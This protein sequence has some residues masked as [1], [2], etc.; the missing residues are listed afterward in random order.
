MEL[1]TLTRAEYESTVQI[2]NQRDSGDKEEQLKVSR[3]LEGFND[4]G[5][6]LKRL[7]L[8]A[9]RRH[10]PNGAVI[11]S[12]GSSAAE[13]LLVVQGLVHAVRPVHYASTSKD[14]KN[15]KTGDEYDVI[16][17]TLIQGKVMGASV[18]LDPFNPR[19]KLTYKC[20]TAVEVIVL[21]KEAFE[22][23]KVTSGVMMSLERASIRSLSIEACTRVIDDKRKDAFNRTMVLRKLKFIPPRRHPDLVEKEWLRKKEAMA[24]EILSG[25]TG[26]TDSLVGRYR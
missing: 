2:V 21:G 10:Y 6:E 17:A 24:D 5:Q 3:A 18:V 26:S 13:L 22:L 11:A 20:A 9:Q 4:Q 25:R 19:Y 12:I 1:L 7:A 8:L 14:M 16:V 23:R 15:K